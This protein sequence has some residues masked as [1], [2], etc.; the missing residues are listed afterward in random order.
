MSVFPDAGALRAPRSLNDLLLYRLSRAARAGGG[1][2]TRM[3]EGGFGITRREWGMIGTLAEVGEI[4]PSAL[5][6]RL[7]LD[8]VRTSRG[9]RSLTEKKLVERR[10][11]TEDRREVHVRLSPSGRQL[12]GELFPRVA[13]LNT[14]LL[15]GIDAAHIEIFLQ[16]LR[17]LEVR[18]T[19]L[20][21]Q[22]VVPEKADRRAGGTR[23]HWPKRGN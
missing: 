21:A 20:S 18:G 14:E 6:Q 23:H 8:R 22:G 2:V 5:A 4:T 17:R 1:M 13:S 7:D 16:C 3:V 9:L 11:D 19:E 15:D 10:Q 12:F